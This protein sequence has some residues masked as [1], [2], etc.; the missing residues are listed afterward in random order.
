MEKKKRLG[1]ETQIFP[2]AV[3]ARIWRAIEGTAVDP[4][5]TP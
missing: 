4:P 3:C 5:D 1:E 2:R